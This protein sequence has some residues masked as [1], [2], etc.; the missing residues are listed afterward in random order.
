MGDRRRDRGQSLLEFAM[1]LPLL[2]LLAVGTIEFGR[3][4]YHYNTLSKA[5]RQAARYITSHEYSAQEQTRAKR[6]AIYG[7]ADGTGS[8]I[9]PGLT[10]SNISITERG[11]GGTTNTDPPEWVK[12]SV[13][14]YTFQTMFRGIV[15]LSASL[16]PGVEMLFMGENAKYEYPTP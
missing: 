12:V 3:A 9:L 2:L 11:G 15:P 10:V 14:G 13:T 5:V 8:P 1:V 4:Y 16:T 7:N 6:M